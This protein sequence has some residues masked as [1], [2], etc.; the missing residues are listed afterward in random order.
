MARKIETAPLPIAPE[1]DVAP[2]DT[3]RNGV[4]GHL[5]FLMAD[6]YKLYE[7]F[8]HKLNFKHAFSFLSFS[9]NGPM[10]N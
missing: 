8:F 1:E 3:D 7:K 2:D 6:F 5:R 9:W 4:D 10:S